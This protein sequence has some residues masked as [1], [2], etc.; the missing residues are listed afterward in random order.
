VWFGEALPE[1]VLAEATRAA[2]TSDVYLSVGTSAEVYP[3]A[4]LPLLACACGAYTVEVNPRPS[5]IADRVDE[6][7][8]SPAAEALPALLQ[9][10]RAFIADRHPGW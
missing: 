4:G 1:A 3:A 7:I 5:Y 6:C 8:E 10:V 2:Q 9:Q